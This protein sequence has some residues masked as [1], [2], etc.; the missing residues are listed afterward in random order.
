MKRGSCTFIFLLILGMPALGQVSETSLRSLYGKPV[1]GSYIVRPGAT[2]A[3]ADGSKGEACVLTIWGP[4]T[5]KELIAIVDQAVPAV[6][7]GLA[8]QSLIECTG[9]CQSIRDYERVTVSSA[10]IGGQSA[11]PAAIITFKSKTCEDRAKE[12]RASG[13]SIT[14]PETPVTRPAMSRP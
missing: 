9:A 8:V 5:E 11:N 4:T 7:R 14:R 10:V 13:F 12:A 2:I 3:T 1:N 6:S